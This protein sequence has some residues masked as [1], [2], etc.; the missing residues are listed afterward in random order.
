MS[1]NNDL[2][3]YHNSPTRTNWA[4]NTIQDAGELAGNSSDP[5]R[6]RSQ[7]ESSL[8]IKDPLFFEKCYILIE[9]DPQKYE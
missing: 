7:F 1:G 4:S 5:R 3:S 8:S 6:T 9:Y 2:I